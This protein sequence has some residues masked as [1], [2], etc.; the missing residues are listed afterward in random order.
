MQ[1]HTKET[2]CQFMKDA[3]LPEP[4]STLPCFDNYEECYC[5]V[6]GY[7]VGEADNKIY[8]CVRK[9]SAR[10]NRV[11]ALPVEDIIHRE[12]GSLVIPYR[13]SLLPIACYMRPGL[14]KHYKGGCYYVHS[15]A[16]LSKDKDSATSPCVLYSSMDTGLPFMWL[17]EKDDWDTSVVIDGLERQRFTY[18]S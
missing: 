13:C 7:A 8:I 17:R 1:R 5:V 11:M 18:I 14:V 3:G 12:N 4:F 2:F 6:V 16:N 9:V 10:L 15:P